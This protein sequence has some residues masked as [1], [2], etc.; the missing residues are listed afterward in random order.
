MK[1]L[2]IALFMVLILSF[3]IIGF[4]QHTDE[5]NDVVEQENDN[6]LIVN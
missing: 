5:P 2:L 4:T 6:T 3:G 1:K